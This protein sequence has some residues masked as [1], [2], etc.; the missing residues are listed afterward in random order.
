MRLL[1]ARITSFIST[2]TAREGGFVEAFSGN[3]RDSCRLFVSFRSKLRGEA[4][5]MFETG[6]MLKN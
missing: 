3:R 2:S 6:Q 4:G 5:G 1:R